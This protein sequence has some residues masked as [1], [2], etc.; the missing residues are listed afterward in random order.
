MNRIEIDLHRKRTVRNLNGN[1]IDMTD[2]YGRPI[3]VKGNVVNQGALD[4]IAFKERDKQMAGQAQAHT[5]EVAPEQVAER[6]QAPAAPSKIQ[7]IEEDVAELK[8]SIG[9]ILALLQNK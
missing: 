3:V 6:T 4:E 8:G 1:I 2:D 7:Q 5:L 9:Q